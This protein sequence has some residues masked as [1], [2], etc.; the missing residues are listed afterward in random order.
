MLELKDRVKQVFGLSP[1]AEP[2][3]VTEMAPVVTAAAEV[4]NGPL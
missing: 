3:A 2:G 1:E 4:K